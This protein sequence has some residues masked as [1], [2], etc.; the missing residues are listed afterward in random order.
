[1]LRT[2]LGAGSGPRLSHDTLDGL[3]Q[4]GRTDPIEYYRRPFVGYLF[5]ERINMGLRMLGQRRFRSLLEVGYG[6]GA[7]LVALAPCVDAMAGIDLD[8]EP[9]IVDRALR[10]RGLDAKLLKG[11]VFEMPY[12]DGAFDLVVSFSVFEHLS[13]YETGLA[14][15]S[16]VLA[17]GGVFLLGMPA[18][19]RTMSRLFELIGH[20]DIDDDHVT[21]PAEVASTFTRH[22]LRVKKRTNLGAPG[23]G[24]A[25][26]YTWLLERV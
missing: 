12:A 9:E 17:P 5:R 26:Y 15:V 11:S 22:R 25:L 6:A 4:N 14:E 7:V 21:T 20:R 1:M 23:G 16:R 8:A 19:N 3:P 24:P 18:V 2:L 13:A 10:A